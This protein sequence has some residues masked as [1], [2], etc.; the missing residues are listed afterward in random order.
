MPAIDTI[1]ATVKIPA[2]IGFLVGVQSV[3]LRASAPLDSDLRTA[4]TLGSKRRAPLL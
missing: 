2:F 3:G 1:F 4:G